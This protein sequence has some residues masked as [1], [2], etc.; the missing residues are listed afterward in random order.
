MAEAQQGLSGAIT[1]WEGAAGDALQAP[2]G[3]LEAAQVGSHPIHDLEQQVVQL[4]LQVKQHTGELK[5]AGRYCHFTFANPALLM[6]HDCTT[7]LSPGGPAWMTLSH[8]KVSSCKWL[9]FSIALM[10]IHVCRCQ[11]CSS[12]TM[13]VW[14]SSCRYRERRSVVVAGW[15]MLPGRSWCWLSAAWAA[16]RGGPPLTP[17]RWRQPRGA[18]WGAACSRPTATSGSCSSLRASPSSRSAAQC[19]P[20]GTDLTLVQLFSALQVCAAACCI[21]PVRCESYCHTAGCR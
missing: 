7:A 13:M 8:K 10:Y 11:D 12:N 17:G 6:C 18:T 9:I 21:H 1:R 19:N 4:E 14:L 15:Q 3:L 20:S 16:A 5:T 2:R